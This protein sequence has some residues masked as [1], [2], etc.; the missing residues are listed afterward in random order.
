MKY[1][2]DASV[3]LQCLLIEV[4]TDLA[5]KLRDNFNAGTIDLL[6]PDI[7]P[8]EVLNALTKAERQ[9]RIT[10]GEGA[11]LARDCLDG[12]PILFSSIGLLPRAYE[13]SSRTR[14]LFM[15]ACTSH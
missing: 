14:A 11:Q 9:Q 8:V 2:F 6:A 3:G 12:L 5:R 7:Y 15:I 4:H 10:Q 13:L 1:V